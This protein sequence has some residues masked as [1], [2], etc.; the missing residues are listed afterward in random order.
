MT[1]PS[2]R[3]VHRFEPATDRGRPPLLLL[4]GTGGDEGDL[5]PLGRVIAP[6]A[7]LLSPRGA[8]L[9]R[10][11]PRFFRRL[12]EGVF[13]EEDLRRRAGDLAAFVIAARERYGIAA[14]IAVGFSNGANI[15]AATLVLHPGLLAGAV[16]IRA[17][18]PMA[19]PPS[20]DLD[21][22]PV[23]ILSGRDDPIVPEENARRLAADLAANGATVDHRVLLTGHGLSQTDVALTTDWLATSAR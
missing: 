15:A 20:A 16:L 19:Q 8:V 17:M 3:F 5:L 23:L 14:P 22:L 21:G 10:G 2:L 11:M 1:D 13:D 12:A 4:H 18:V 9:E 6:G 7:A